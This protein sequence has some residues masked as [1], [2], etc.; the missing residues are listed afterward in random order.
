MKGQQGRRLGVRV[1]ALVDNPEV[2]DVKSAP[3][4]CAALVEQN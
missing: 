3:L 2:M 1:F 4:K